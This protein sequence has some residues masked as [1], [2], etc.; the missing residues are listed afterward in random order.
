VASLNKVEATLYQHQH[1]LTRTRSNRA[2]T[3]QQ[4]DLVSIGQIRH[5]HCNLSTNRAT[6]SLTFS[7]FDN[8]DEDVGMWTQKAEITN[9]YCF[10]SVMS[11]TTTW[12]TAKVWRTNGHYSIDCSDHGNLTRSW[13]SDLGDLIEFRFVGR[14]TTTTTKKE[15]SL[16]YTR[17]VKT[18]DS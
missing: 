12:E 15:Q 16:E 2:R 10:W 13:K 9:N 4:R 6:I 1:R 11:L 7:W 5:C 8:E 14:C 3:E 17:Q 18:N